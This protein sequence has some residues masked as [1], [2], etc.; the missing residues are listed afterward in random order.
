[1]ISNV[2]AALGTTL[3]IL[4]G[5]LVGFTI[6]QVAYGVTGGAGT[7]YFLTLLL[8]VAS[9]AFLSSKDTPAVFLM[10]VLA[11]LFAGIIGAISITAEN[12]AGQQEF[13]ILV[14]LIVACVHAS[15][16]I[17]YGYG[18]DKLSESKAEKPAPKATAKA[19]TKA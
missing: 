19:S 1:M 17:Y 9:Y 18:L 12:P 8:A 10:D 14:C 3:G 7:T 15:A 11:F 4:F 16:A 5:I 2:K 6:F 13:V